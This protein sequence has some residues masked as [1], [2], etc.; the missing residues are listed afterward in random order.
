LLLHT[1]VSSISATTLTKNVTDLKTQ[2]AMLHTSTHIM[3][4]SAAA[5]GEW[6]LVHQAA[7]DGGSCKQA[8]LEHPQ[9]VHST[10]ALFQI[11]LTWHFRYNIYTYK[12][13]D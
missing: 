12:V 10:H 7:A 3:Q 1:R 9:G 4:Q 11:Q 2:H 5:L 13:T 8:T 6:Q